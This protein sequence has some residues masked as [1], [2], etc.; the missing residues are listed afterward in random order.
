[1]RG[2][3]VHN[4]VLLGPVEQVA[5][6]LPDVQVEPEAAIEVGNQTLYA[7]LLITIGSKRILIEA[8]MSARRIEKD[9]EKAIAFE[10]CELWIVV[11]DPKVRKSV[12]RKL[13]AQP[14]PDKRL[15]VLVLFFSQAIE[16]VRE[17]SDLNSRTIVRENKWGK[18]NRSKL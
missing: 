15:S 6:N 9:L 2:G 14:K 3:H 8:E 11:P 10:Q 16:R 13:A 17:L 4:R 12:Q 18:Q 7:D 5:S 1:M